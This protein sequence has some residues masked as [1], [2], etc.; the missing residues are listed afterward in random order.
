[1]HREEE[2]G[3]LVVGLQWPLGPHV[4]TKFY[5]PGLRRME[6]GMMAGVLW[7][8]TVRSVS[9]QRSRTEKFHHNINMNRVL[10]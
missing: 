2:L 9:S 5:R 1:M 3:I 8:W 10:Q 7:N 4:N 6:G